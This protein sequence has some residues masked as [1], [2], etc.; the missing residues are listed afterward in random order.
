MFSRE[1][2]PPVPNISPA[3]RVRQTTAHQPVLSLG[4]DVDHNPKPKRGNSQSFCPLL[5]LRVVISPTLQS[6]ASPTC[7]T[8]PPALKIP[9]AYRRLNIEIPNVRRPQQSHPQQPYH[10]NTN[11]FIAARAQALRFFF[12][13]SIQSG[14]G[15][16]PPVP[17]FKVI[18][19]HRAARA[20][21]LLIPS[22]HV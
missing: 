6:R 3:H 22:P 13:N 19:N 12:L 17:L 18:T 1:A 10:S 11:P 20:A 14:T 2:R 4:I 15:A 21:P 16:S 9:R 7:S 5:T 8:S